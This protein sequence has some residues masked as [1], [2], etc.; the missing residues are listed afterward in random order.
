MIITPPRQF[1]PPAAPKPIPE[2]PS[3]RH[4]R[5]RAL[6]VAA[7]VGCVALGAGLRVAAYARNQSLWIDEAMLA[8]NVVH[9]TP[10]GLLQP[11]DLNQGAPV[12]YLLLSKFVVH[13]F[14]SSELMLRLTSFVASL[15]GLALFV[16]LAYRALP[17]A[18]ARLAVCLFALSPYLVGYA[19]EFKQYELDAT[20]AVALTALAL[21][22]WRGTAGRVGLVALALAGMVAVWFSHPSV[23]VLGGVGLAVLAEPLMRRDYRALLGRLAVVGAWVASFAACYLLFTRKLGDNQY[24]LDYWAGA[25]L[26]LPPTRPGDFAWIVHHFLLFFE[27]PGGLNPAE[28]GAGGLAAAFYLV[29]CVVLWQ[30]DRRALVALVAPL[31]LAMLASGLGK[32]PFAG[33]LLLFAVPSAL[34]V[35]GY[36]AAVVAGR[37]GRG[38]PAAAVLLIGLL[39]VGPTALCAWGLRKPVHAEDAREVIAHV[40]A[41]WRAGDVAYVSHGAAPAFAFYQ[42]R[43]PFPADAVRFA[44]DPRGLRH[45]QQLAEVRT[46]RGQRRVWVVLAHQTPTD[47]ATLRAYLDSLGRRDEA[48]SK[49]A[50]AVLRYDLSAE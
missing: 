7:V 41:H 49:S 42:S 26:P 28:F 47:E 48:V 5:L 31:F 43:F 50:A 32:Y 38:Q 22:A 15:A 18:A 45:G 14:G 24:L 12:G 8:L 33:R 19:A 17:A 4:R 10:S 3:P 40:H 46:L 39:F 1:H 34:L 44:A 30:T 2:P 35:V 11:L 21:P 23:F 29:G 37:V 6:A 25:F 27:K 9:R 20:I 36:G 16:P 13:Q